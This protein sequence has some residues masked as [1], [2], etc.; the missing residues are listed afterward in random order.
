M[1]ATVM[2]PRCT[3]SAVHDRISTKSGKSYRQALIF[4]DGAMGLLQVFVSD[5]ATPPP[6]GQPITVQFEAQVGYKGDLRFAWNKDT[7]FK[8]L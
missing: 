4:V 5:D 8:A 1:S 6:V 2:F 7:K 3:V